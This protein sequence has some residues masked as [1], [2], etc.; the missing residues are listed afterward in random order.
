[1][2]RNLDG[3][4]PL[5]LCINIKVTKANALLDSVTMRVHYLEKKYGV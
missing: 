2:P 5:V 1:V 3:L 4:G